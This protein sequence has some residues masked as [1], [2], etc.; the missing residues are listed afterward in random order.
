MKRITMIVLTLLLHAVALRAQWIQTN[1]P[2]G[3]YIAAMAAGRDGVIA[4]AWPGTV[5]RYDQS[6]DVWT[7]TGNVAAYK[8]EA[9]GNVFVASTQGGMMRSDDMGATWTA[10][11]VA[12]TAVIA[13][14]DGNNLYAIDDSRLYRSTDGGREWAEFGQD[15]DTVGAHHFE[16]V[17]LTA[18]GDTVVVVGNRGV[19]GVIRSFDRGFTWEVA[20]DGLPAG[21]TISVVQFVG[22]TLAAQVYDSLSKVSLGIYLSNDM[23]TTWSASNEGRIEN[24]S[25][26]YHVYMFYQEGESLAAATIDGTIRLEGERWVGTSGKLISGIAVDPAGKIYRS[27]F[28]GI[29][30]S[31]DQG[32]TWERFDRGI[33]NQNVTAMTSSGRALIAASGNG[34]FRSIDKGLNWTRTGEIRAEQFVHNN[35]V[36]LARGSRYTTQGIL[37]STDSGQIWADAN[38]GIEHSLAWITS[39][40]ATP[41]VAYVTISSPNPIDTSERVYEGGIYRSSDFGQTWEQ[42]TEG[43][44]QRNDSTLGFLAIAADGDTAVALGRDGI[45]RTTDGGDTWEATGFGFR[46]FGNVNDMIAHDGR[47]Y[48]AVTNGVWVSSDAGETWQLTGGANLPSIASALSIYR[49][50]VTVVAGSDNVTAAVMS[51]VGNRWV[52]IAAGLPGNS[53]VRDIVEADGTTYLATTTS[54]VLRLSDGSAGVDEPGSTLATGWSSLPLRAGSTLRIDL[55]KAATPTIELV[56]MAGRTVLHVDAGMLAAG[57]YTVALP[58]DGLEAGVYA[59]RISADGEVSR[60]SVI[61]AE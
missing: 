49:D 54:S 20:G 40:A 18:R 14:S 29:S 44:P 22:R 52:P 26:Y 28:S 21:S 61:V 7:K 8:M 55:K 4:I 36:L 1:G 12:E 56:D 2:E 35:D 46:P 30:R 6:H 48:A 34:I 60:G 39:I 33:L 10:M 45:F 24:E 53:A 17:S 15:W 38:M 50:A 59:Y 19:T 13:E 58:I 51:L 23:G 31:D 3:G 32:V 16:A 43:L 11:N 5:Y 9:A 25:G 47:F 42:L 57:N 37:R 27:D 41:E